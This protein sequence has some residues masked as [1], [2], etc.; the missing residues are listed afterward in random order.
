EK[1]GWPAEAVVAITFDDPVGSNRLHAREV[2]R[3]VEALREAT[4]APAVDIVAHSMG[5]LAVRRYLADGGE[6]VRRVAFLGTP[7]HGTYTAWLAWGDGGREMRPGS[8]FLR[9]LAVDWAGVRTPPALTVRTLIDTHVIPGRSAVL[10][11]ADNRAVCCPSHFGLR[12][13]G[14]VYRIARDFLRWSGGPGTADPD[15][16]APGAGAEGPSD[17]GRDGSR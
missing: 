15:A 13:N 16:E 17:S 9:E 5:G 2:G 14:T 7:H 6:G 4:G 10:E 11:G 8:T 3:A 1:D 12:W